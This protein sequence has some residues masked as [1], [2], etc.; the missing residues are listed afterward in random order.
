M[1][2]I[3]IDIATRLPFVCENAYGSSTRVSPD[4]CLLA[5]GMRADLASEHA[6]DERIQ[7]QLG[8]L[9]RRRIAEVKRAS[10]L[11]QFGF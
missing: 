11:A 10:R 3:D 9:E 8:V 6:L 5:N 7:Q 1:Q 2:L 4:P